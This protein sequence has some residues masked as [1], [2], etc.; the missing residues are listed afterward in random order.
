MPGAGSISHE[1]DV[2]LLGRTP[3]LWRSR[4]ELV[5]G[6]EDIGKDWNGLNKGFHAVVTSQPTVALQF[7]VVNRLWPRSEANV[8]EESFLTHTDP[9][10]VRQSRHRPEQH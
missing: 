9:C 4:I 8:V 5:Q 6:T 3:A 2:S 10:P 1:K 7:V